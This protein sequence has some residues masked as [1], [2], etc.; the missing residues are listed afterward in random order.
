[1]TQT[2]AEETSKLLTQLQLRD[3]VV[4]THDARTEVEEC[5]RLNTA[6]NRV[7][8]NLLFILLEPAR[9]TYVE[10]DHITLDFIQGWV[11]RFR[12]E[13]FRL[14]SRTTL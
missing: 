11:G 6:W 13:F 14:E 12:A 9:V 4:L 3:V 8:P 5:M 1:M 10:E 2:K 7:A